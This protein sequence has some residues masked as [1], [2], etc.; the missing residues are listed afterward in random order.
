M[1]VA[2]LVGAR[3]KSRESSERSTGRSSNN[4]GKSMRR[5]K[6]E[7]LLDSLNPR[8]NEQK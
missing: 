2:E 6:S 1:D 3:R 7:L 5:L 8:V 4:G